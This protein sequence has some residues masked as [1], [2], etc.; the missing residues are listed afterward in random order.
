MNKEQWAG[1][2]AG[3]GVA[4]TIVLGV[5]TA[6]ASAG[7]KAD[8]TNATIIEDFRFADPAGTGL[9]AAANAAGT[10]HLFDG[11]VDTAYVATTGMGQLDASLKANTN[12]GTNYVD[13]DVLTPADGRVL[14]VMELTW[15]FESTLDPS[16]NE[17]IRLSFMQFDP[18]T[19]FVVAEWEIQREDDDTLTI[20]GNGVGA[21]AS[22]LGPVV[23]NGGSL[24][25]SSTFIAVVDA[26]M[27]TDEYFVHFSSDAGATFTTLGP[28][29]LDPTRD[30]IESFRLTLNNDL[31]NDNVLIDRIYLATII[32]EPA[33][34]TAMMVLSLTLR[35]VRRRT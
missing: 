17:E 4:S 11:D 9:P 25:Q 16:E 23:L 27:A 10:G 35:R 1:C 14:G 20:L 15:D 26:D 12:F 21:G 31:S 2:P 3:V 22:D 8:L 30:T 33:S 5:M 18:R 6:T 32:P 34:L 7:I 29:Q 19:T 13:N 28:G 24:S